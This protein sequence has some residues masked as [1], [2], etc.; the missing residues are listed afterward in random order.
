MSY[1][2]NQIGI[3]TVHSFNSIINIYCHSV[4]S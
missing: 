3:F 1:E 2:K 4:V